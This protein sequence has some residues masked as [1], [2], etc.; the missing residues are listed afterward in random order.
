MPI[1]KLVH[2]IHSFQKGYFARH[3]ALFAELAAKGQRPNTL[4]LTCS[5]SRILPE[6]LTSTGPGE[7]FIVRNV[8]NVIPRTDLV[9]GTAAAIE[10]GI[11]VLGVDHI[12]VCGH[13]QCGA[14]DAIMDPQ[15]MESLP[16]VK[17][18]LSQTERVREVI[19]ARY[20]DLPIEAQK[21][22]AVEE[23]VLMQL[24]NLR[25]YPFAQRR[26][27]AGTL[28]LS[29]WVLDVEKGTV[30]DYD[31]ALCEFVPLVAK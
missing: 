15:R 16:Y 11:E 3:R 26:L 17:R 18:W 28:D 2:G 22:A 24:E 19:A 7:L 29:G 20:S 14:I 10:Y 9:G 4:F 12:V 25:D 5:D 6:R 31:A 21:M 23:N 27:D 8:G 30:F 1:Q 13:T